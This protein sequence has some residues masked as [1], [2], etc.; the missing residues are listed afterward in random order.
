MILRV[1][2]VIVTLAQ[3]W[4]L[5]RWWSLHTS[6]HFGTCPSS[7]N[8][9]FTANYT[10]HVTPTVMIMSWTNS[11]LV[12]C[13]SYNKVTPLVDYKNYNVIK[14]TVTCSGHTPK[15]HWTLKPKQ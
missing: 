11:T 6:G 7:L 13:K 1:K 14:K 15:Y 8:Q 9:R 12:D 5:E 3:L 2:P 4:P 10:V